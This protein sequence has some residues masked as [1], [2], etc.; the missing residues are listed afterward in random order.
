MPKM[1]S[2]IIQYT[3]VKK[4]N[5]TKY[6]RRSDWLCK[7]FMNRAVSHLTNGEQLW[8]AAQNGKFLLAETGQ[9][10]RVTNKRKETIISG[11]VTFLWGE[12]V[13]ILPGRAPH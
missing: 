11:R 2:Q 1:H 13:R 10:K 3:N 5:S 12:R 9:D 4:Q 7:Q 8:E 6:I